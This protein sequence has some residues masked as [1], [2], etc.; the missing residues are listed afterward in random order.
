MTLIS[1]NKTETN[2]VV[3]EISVG[4]EEFENAVAAAFRKNA[5]KINVRGFRPGK[6]P[7]SYIE[8]VY[9]KEIFYEDAVNEL[10]P[11]AYSDAVAEAGIE[12]VDRADIEVLSIDEN[13]IPFSLSISAGSI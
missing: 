8:K 5:S 13:E 1:Q 2:T 4:A 9:G 7:R 12:P 6:A 11:V 3:L 10:Y